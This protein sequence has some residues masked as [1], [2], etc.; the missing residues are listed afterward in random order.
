MATENLDFAAQVDEWV[1][2]QQNRML[3]V[4]RESTQRLIS[5]ISTAVPVDTGFCRASVRVS[6]DSMPQA[7]GSKPASAAPGSYNFDPGFASAS[8]AALQPGQTIY[9]GWTANYAI[10]LEYG[11]SQQA[12]NGFVRVG[13]AQWPQIVA[14]VTAEAKAV[15]G[16]Q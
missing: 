3:A 6:L 4:A 11:H 16:A 12:P 10:Y 2:A 9:V 7:I 5:V 14:E 1:K 15:A 13:C 8:L